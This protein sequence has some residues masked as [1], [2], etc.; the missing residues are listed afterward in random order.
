MLVGDEVWDMLLYIN[1]AMYWRDDLITSL[2]K[3][4]Q[5]LFLAD[6]NSIE[7]GYYNYDRLI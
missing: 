1:V 6:E 7:D 2:V 4:I 3:I 5:Y